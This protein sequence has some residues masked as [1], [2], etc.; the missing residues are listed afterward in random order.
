MLELKEVL[1][2][3][4]PPKYALFPRNVLLINVKF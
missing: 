2:N 1:M 4:P 3:K